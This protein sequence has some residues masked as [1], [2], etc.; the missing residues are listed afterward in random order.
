MQ[1]RKKYEELIRDGN[2]VYNKVRCG[3][4]HSYLIETNSLI[5]LGK[6]DCGITIDNTNGKYVFNIIT[7]FEDFKKVVDTYIKGLGSEDIKNRKDF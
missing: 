6:G 5:K 7:Y 1:I 4:V 2:D 3:L